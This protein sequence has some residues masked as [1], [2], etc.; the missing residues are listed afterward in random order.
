MMN[1][2]TNYLA[3]KAEIE[4]LKKQVRKL[5]CE[6]S[7]LRGLTGRKKRRVRKNAVLAAYKPGMT[8]AELA[9]IAG[10]SVRYAN[11]V[12]SGLTS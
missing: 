5:Q 10:C 7:T 6:N 3:L 9:K 1:D 8:G 11:Y 4:R 12:K 2:L